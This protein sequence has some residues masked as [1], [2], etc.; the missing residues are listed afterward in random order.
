MEPGP[1]NYQT[2]NYTALGSIKSVPKFSLR[3][4]S[5]TTE[6]GYVKPGQSRPDLGTYTPKYHKKPAYTFKALVE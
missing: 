2:G 1:T 5:R 6:F 4:A 3:K